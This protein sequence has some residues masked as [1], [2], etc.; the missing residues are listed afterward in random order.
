MAPKER[1]MV[2]DLRARLAAAEAVNAQHARAFDALV[3][4]GVLAREEVEEVA[5]AVVD[6]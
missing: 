6:R 1:E 3:R 5:S 2:E 4:K